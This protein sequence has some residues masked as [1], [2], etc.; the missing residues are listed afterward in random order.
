MALLLR[1]NRYQ[2]MEGLLYSLQG[3]FVNARNW[4][5]DIERIAFWRNACLLRTKVINLGIA[6]PVTGL[7]CGLL[8]E[9]AFVGLDPA[10]ANHR[11]WTAHGFITALAMLL[12]TLSC[13]IVEICTP[14]LFQRWRRIAR[15]W[16]AVRYGWIALWVAA[17][18]AA[19]ADGRIGTVTSIAL[20]VLAIATLWALAVHG[21][22]RMAGLSII[23]VYS[24]CGFGFV[25]YYVR[26]AS[27]PWIVP[28][29]QG[30]LYGMFV[31]FVQL[32]LRAIVERLRAVRVAATIV[33]FAA[34]LATVFS[35]MGM[36]LSDFSPAWSEPTWSTYA[37]LIVAG[38]VLGTMRW[39]QVGEIIP[40]SFLGLLS[41]LWT[42]ASMAEPRITAVVV[43]CLMAYWI[44]HGMRRQHVRVRD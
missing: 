36:L 20:V 24:A 4:R 23:A 34:S 31:G 6:A 7:W 39:G 26:F 14:S 13:G 8:I 42:G 40:Q 12:T 41:I 19:Y 16:G 28:L 29:A 27:G 15:G 5:F 32:E 1:R 10:S 18:C 22:P 35:L 30:V 3:L 44:G 38:G 17:T 25:G 21:W 43:I 2:E 33:W 9:K 37:A 11:I